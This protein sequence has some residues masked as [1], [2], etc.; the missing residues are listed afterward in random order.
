MKN[1]LIKLTDLAD[2]LGHKD[3]RTI[4]IWCDDN[5]VPTMKLGKFYYTHNWLV[6]IALMRILHKESFVSGLDADGIIN[7][8]VSDDKV[9]L[10]E[11]MDA[12]LDE[13]VKSNSKNKNHESSMDEILKSYKT[14]G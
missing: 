14:A 6:D 5:S 7:A 3:L 8:L 13:S 11:L 2:L 10:S 12:P 4:K 9:R 1:E